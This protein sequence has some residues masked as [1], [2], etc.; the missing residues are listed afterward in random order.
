MIKISKKQRLNKLEL[1]YL[2]RER[3]KINPNLIRIELQLYGKRAI[4]NLQLFEKLIQKTLKMIK[5]V[6]R[7]CIKMNKRE[8]KFLLEFEYEN[9]PKILNNIIYSKNE[10]KPP[11]S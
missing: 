5:R 3:E 7:L 8:L 10:I 6:K 4:Y 1:E 9:E 11:P 2:E